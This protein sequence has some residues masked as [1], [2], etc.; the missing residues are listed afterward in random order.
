[1]DSIEKIITGKTTLPSPPLICIK[2]LELVRKDDFTFQDLA[3]V[4][5]V[6]PSLTA[7]LL[8]VANTTYY[9]RSG[10]I[11][12]VAKAVAILGVNVVKII[13]LSF[14]VYNE[15]QTE[16]GSTFDIDLFWR[17]SLT[18]AV[19][20]EQISHALKVSSSDLFLT[21]L[22]QDIGVV[23]MFNW[24]PF[25]YQQISKATMNEHNSLL[26]SE[27]DLF[28]FDHQIAGSELFKSWNFPEEI[29]LPVQ[30]HHS[31]EAAPQEYRRNIDILD[32]ANL[33]SSFYNDNYDV[34]KF[35]RVKQSLISKLGFEDRAAEDL[36]EA[37]AHKSREMFSAFEISDGNMKSLSQILQEANEEL[38]SLYHSYELIMLELKQAKEKS[39]ALAQEL[40]EA[41]ER[42]RELAYKDSLT[43][44]YNLRFFHDALGSEIVRSQRYGR[45]FSLLLFDLDNLKEINDTYGHLAGSQALVNISMVVQKN[46]R[47]TD[48]F[49]RLGGDEFGV[50]LPETNVSSACFVAEQI[51]NSIETST[52]NVPV[53]ISLGLTSYCS[54]KGDWNK[55]M[56]FNKADEALYLAKKNGKNRVHVV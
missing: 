31:S 50:I 12:N 28:G 34:M 32:V 5:G 15:F 13:A 47:G 17:R 40:H 52:E 37:I 53:T 41:N 1:L 22:L 11:T 3:G 48:I 38:G 19:A 56:I 29:Y 6:D 46:I 39:D 42:H 2:I 51:R 55:V 54:D 14:V 26:Q 18:S 30:F 36:I 20:A 25:D 9:N 16:E 23:I 4:I 8:K 44:V 49:A 45:E 7:K 21:A 10:Q 35:K 43:Q 33:L 24:R 27:H